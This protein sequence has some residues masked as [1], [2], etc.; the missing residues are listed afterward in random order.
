M[1]KKRLEHVCVRLGHDG[2]IVQGYGGGGLGDG[3]VKLRDR[4][5]CGQLMVVLTP[6]KCE[7]YAPCRINDVGGG[8]GILVLNTVVETVGKV[9]VVVRRVM[10]AVS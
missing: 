10:V 6:P 5:V 2:G 8:L 4:G 3:N 7:T 1:A 9:T